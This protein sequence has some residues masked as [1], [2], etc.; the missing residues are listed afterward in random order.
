MP[1]R[2]PII[3]QEFAQQYGLTLES[4]KEYCQR[5]YITK[6]SARERVKRGKAYAYQVA[7]HWYFVT[8]N[9]EDLKDI[10]L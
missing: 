6:A 8:K 4:M 10:I 7:K 2:C 9:G 5:N 1:R 3:S